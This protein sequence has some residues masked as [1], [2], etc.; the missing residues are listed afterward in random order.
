MF[1]PLTGLSDQYS[2]GKAARVWQLYIGE[3]S[4]RT[5]KY[6]TFL[7]D[8]LRERKCKNVL[9]AACGTG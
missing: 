6:K 2:D 1:T 8:I 3:A 5:D 9:D 7:V 4:E